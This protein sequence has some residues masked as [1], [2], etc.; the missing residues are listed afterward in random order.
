MRCIRCHRPMKHATATG[1]GPVCG[2]AVAPTPTV[3]RDL[4]GFDVPAAA[5]AAVERVTVHVQQLA[6][7]AHVAVRREFAAARR[8]LGVLA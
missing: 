8:R 2:K 7:E 6:V 5:R 1:L 4:F 3:E